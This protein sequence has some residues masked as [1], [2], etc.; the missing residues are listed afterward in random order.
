MT[1]NIFEHIDPRAEVP[2]VRQKMESQGKLVSQLQ[3]TGKELWSRVD[4]IIDQTNRQVEK[5]DKQEGVKNFVTVRIYRVSVKEFPLK[6]YSEINIDGSKD[7]DIPY[8]IDQRIF[9]KHGWEER[10]K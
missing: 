4:S 6:G 1:L 7:P 3:K 2:E 9:Q 10:Y 8:D 5:Q